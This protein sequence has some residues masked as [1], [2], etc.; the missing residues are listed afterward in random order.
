LKSNNF[1]QVTMLFK[2]GF[3]LCFLLLHLGVQSRDIPKVGLTKEVDVRENGEEIIPEEPENEIESKPEGLTETW[4]DQMKNWLVSGLNEKYAQLEES[5]ASKDDEVQQLKRKFEEWEKDDNNVQKL[6]N[7]LIV[8]QK[9]VQS[10]TT[11]VESK[12]GEIEQLKTDM[13]GLA[14]KDGEAKKVYFS[15]YLDKKGYVEDKLKFPKVLVNIGEAF[16][17]PTGV[18]KAPFKGVYSFSFSGQQ[19]TSVESGSYIEVFVKKNGQTV[20]KIMDDANT[21]GQD[22]IWQNINSS[23]S[24]ELEE[25]DTV[26][27]ELNANDKLFANGSERLTFM[28]QLINAA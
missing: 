7:N 3:W 1:D 24:L 27:L 2:G 9:Q 6:K 26:Y 14:S 22:Q 28:G 21:S 13:E 18:F 17:G 25:N 23:F 4:L 16:D 5:I 11:T 10:L 20:F 12:N 19:G 15:A 8:L